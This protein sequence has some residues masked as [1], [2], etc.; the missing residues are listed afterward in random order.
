M[1][2]DADK[3][4]LDSII[5]RLLDGRSCI[6]FSLKF[7][8]VVLVLVVLT[9]SCVNDVVVFSISSARFSSW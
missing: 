5:Q 4:N 2:T 1:A 6:N 9:S 3:V 7:D 8:P